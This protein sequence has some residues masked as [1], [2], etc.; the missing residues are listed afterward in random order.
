MNI[1]IIQP[2]AVMIKPLAEC[3]WWSERNVK[4]IVL[5]RNVD[6]EFYYFVGLHHSYTCTQLLAA[7]TIF[8]PHGLWHIYI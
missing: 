8:S 7:Y 5:E 2:A 4:H 6:N 3:Y 1:L